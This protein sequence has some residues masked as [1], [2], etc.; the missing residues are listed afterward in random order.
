MEK[1]KKTQDKGVRVRFAPSPTGRLHIGNL[2]AA[3]FNWL[4]ARHHNGKF[5]LRIEDTDKER[6]KKEYQDYMLESLKWVGINYDEEPLVQSSRI[7]TH[8]A[9]I[10]KLIEE[11]KAYKCYCMQEDIENRQQEKL[12]HQDLYQGYDGFCR[13]R[14]ESGEAQEGHKPY[15]V[16]FRLPDKKSITFHDLI[17]GEITFELNQFDD[18]IIAR[19]DGTPMYN[20]AVVVDDDFMNITHVIRGEDHISNTPKQIMLYEACGFNVPQFAHVPLILGPSGDKLSKRDAAVS[21]LEYREQGFLPEALFNYLVRLG[22]SHG[23][24]EVFSKDELV[25]FFDLDHVGKKGAIFDIDKLSWLNG[26]YLREHDPHDLKREIEVSLKFSFTDKLAKWDEQKTIKLIDLYKERVKTLKE[27]VDSLVLLYEGPSGYDEKALDKWVTQDTKAHIQSLVQY[28]EKE[29]DF[30][31]DM[32]AKNI[33]ALSKELGI[34]LVAL[35]QPIRISLTG[36]SASPGVFELLE[37]VGKQESVKRI[38][39]FIHKIG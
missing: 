3:I 9:A 28:L 39:N 19:S 24:Q 15:V 35:A 34:K 30:T 12:G 37:I 22:W 2:R 7:D 18:F 38:K 1:E 23:D 14:A 36:S 33:K 31:H 26:V 13:Q 16:R 20:L 8:I 6:S 10:N 4:F 5:L 25:S 27:L 11:G 17:R 21:V 29:D 32:L